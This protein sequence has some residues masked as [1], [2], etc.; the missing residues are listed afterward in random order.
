MFETK[1]NVVVD[2]IGTNQQRR[3]EYK[4]KKNYDT[5]QEAREAVKYCLRKAEKQSKL[6]KYDLDYSNPRVKKITIEYEEII[7]ITKHTIN[8]TEEYI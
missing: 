4:D 5:L 3:V 6:N 8:T 7:T 2:V 1:Y